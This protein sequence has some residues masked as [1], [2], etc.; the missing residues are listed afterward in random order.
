MIHMVYFASPNIYSYNFTTRKTLIKNFILNQMKIPFN[1][2]RCIIEFMNELICVQNQ[3]CLLHFTA[4]V[5]M[6]IDSPQ[7]GQYDMIYCIL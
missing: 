1:E 7:K 3:K 4:N 6:I 2:Q 5:V